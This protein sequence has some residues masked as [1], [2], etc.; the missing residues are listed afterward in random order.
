[1]SSL[2]RCAFI[3]AFSLCCAGLPAAANAQTKTPKKAPAGSV[4]G[5]ITLH[6]KGA[7]GIV[8]GIRSA[9]FSQPPA[10]TF[11][12]TTDPDG[13]YR[14]TGIPVGN[15]L[16]AP[17]APAYVLPGLMS[18]S[19]RGTALLLAEGEDVQDVDFS[20]D[21]GGVIT[22]RVTEADG[23]PVVEER[24]LL[25]PLD[26]NNQNLQRFG[27]M[28]LAGAQTDDRGVYRIYGLPAGRYKIS[29]GRDDDNYYSSGG[30]G[31]VTYKRTF[32]PDV[33]D[34][35]EA[36][37][38]EVTEGSEATNIDITLGQTL[39]GFVASGKVVDGETGQP[40]PGL[41]FGLRRMINNDYA[42]IN[43]SV[44]SNSQGEFRLENVTPG[45]YAVMI[46]PVQGME[47]RA[48]AVSFEVVDQDVTGLLVKTF[49]GLSIS[50][51]V[52]VDG[53]NDSSILA[54]LAELRL[55]AYVRNEG[56]N[57]S[58]GQSSV[59]NPDGSFR[60]GGLSAGT[61]NFSLGSQ[62]GRPSVNFAILRIERDGVVQPP[63][64][65]EL[66]AGEQQVTG[67]KIVLRYG[68]GSVRGEVKFENGP[69]PDGGRVMVWLRK[70]GE[71][72][73][74]FRPS[75]LDFRGHFLIEGVSAG[76]YELH[77]QANVPG[78]R[79]ASARQPVTVAEGA[80][81]DVVMSLD[82]NPNPRQKPGP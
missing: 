28:S 72:D 29:V 79:S 73:S 15:Y 48:D 13:N 77:V 24:L 3:L 49:K 50:G 26:Q 32:Y 23:R 54:K 42:G 20:L 57:Q 36:K 19:S 5:R 66:N 65:F 78:R 44:P 71:T 52:V 34:P 8:V 53:K 41:R 30:T 43:S 38:I 12:A 62:D 58:F 17:M 67:V 64:G 35:A 37:I 59:I 11:K 1:M 25:V 39:P 75:T 40:V 81:S 60:V 55:H 80:V 2:P 63:R 46:L 51:T 18:F 10:A 69:L 7:A 27:P 14:I 9:D 61:A 74:N 82:L 47:T 6:G 45:K 31:R 56:A 21:R 16:V 70:P 22:G 76:D 33:T 68:T 4:S